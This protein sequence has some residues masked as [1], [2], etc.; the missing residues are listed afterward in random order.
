MTGTV[1]WWNNTKGYGFITSCN[2]D[3]F[4]HYSSINKN[5]YKSLE[6]GQEVEFDIKETDRGLEAINVSEI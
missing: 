2:K 5:G 1:K 4:V 6:D 3:Y